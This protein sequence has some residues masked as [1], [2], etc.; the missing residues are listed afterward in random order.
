MSAHNRPAGANAPR[1]TPISG[2]SGPGRLSCFRATP[3]ESELVRPDMNPAAA[4]ASMYSESSSYS[5]KRAASTSL[6][7]S[8]AGEWA[9]I[10]TA[11]TVFNSPL[12]QAA[13]T[14]LHQDRLRSGE[15]DT[16]D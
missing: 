4:A 5:G 12:T 9:I 15:S 1:K 2:P 14:V 3:A 13:E 10:S 11:C 6:N 16:A 7:L 8:E